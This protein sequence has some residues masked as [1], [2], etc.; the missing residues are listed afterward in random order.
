ME[1]FSLAVA[2]FAWSRPLHSSYPYP[3][4][5]AP[6]SRSLLLLLLALFDVQQCLAVPPL[7][8]DSTTP[9]C[10]CYRPTGNR[11]AVFLNH[12]FFDFRSL[13]NETFAS[14]LTTPA[15][16]RNSQN[17][18][19]EPLTS[20]FFDTGF[21][22]DYFT[23]GSW[24]KELS[25]VAPVSMVNSHQ[26]LYLGERSAYS[27]T[28]TSF[29]LM[30]HCPSARDAP[31]SPVH[32]TLRTNRLPSFQSASALETT[33]IAYMH[34]SI[35]IRARISGSPGACAGMFTYLTDEQ[36]S[37]IEILTRDE[38]STVRATNQPGVVSHFL[39]LRLHSNPLTRR[40]TEQ[41]IPHHKLISPLQDANGTVVPEASTQIAITR[42]GGTAVGSWTDWNDYQLNWLPGRSEWLINGMSKLNKT[43]GVPTQPSNIQIRMWSN[44]G[45]WTGNMTVGGEATLDIEW[46]D[47][48]YNTSREAP[49]ATCKTVCSMDNFARDPR[50]QIAN[51]TVRSIQVGTSLWALVLCPFWAA[52]SLW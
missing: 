35:H 2:G 9:E 12:Q 33:E 38:K 30:Q 10:S 48:V 14:N 18:G 27:Y 5:P 47:L 41:C 23:P 39:L 6:S 31:D 20:P 28:S 1:Y 52:M 11:E 34:A 44:G 32:L 3:T 49:G 40:C 25:E 4:M 15:A 26:N 29:R 16:I 8:P 21:F 24:S 19:T 43:Y 7:S 17:E 45:S 46:I 36:E 37:D 13:D 42:P 51:G 50:P 22:G